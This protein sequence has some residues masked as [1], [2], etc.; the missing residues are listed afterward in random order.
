MTS[1]KSRRVRRTVGTGLSLAL[2]A[3]AG[4]AATAPLAS[5]FA[6][7]RASVVAPTAVTPKAATTPVSARVVAT[8]KIGVAPKALVATPCTG[9]ATISCELFARTGTTTVKVSASSSPTLTVWKFSDTDTATGAASAVLVGQVGVPMTITLHNNLP[10]ATPLRFSIP[11]LDG[12]HFTT[13]IAQGGTDTV[14]FTPDRA[15]TF[16]YQAGLGADGSRQ[17]SMGLVGALVV[18]PNPAQPSAVPGDDANQTKGKAYDAQEQGYDDEAV[19]VYT[20]VDTRLAANPL[21]FSMRSW[22]PQYH[23]VNGQA[24]PDTQSVVSDAGRT[25]MLRVV[26]GGILEKSPTLLGTR[27]TVVARGS[28]PLPTAMEVSGRLMN[29]GDTFDGRVT[30]PA[31]ADTRYALF[32][33]PGGLR[34]ANG[35]N[36][37]SKNAPALGGALVFLQAGG[38]PNVAPSGPKVST[39][40]IT[41]TPGVA[42]A[43]GV[44]ARSLTLSAKLSTADRGE[45]DIADGEYWIDNLDAGA[46]GQLDGVGA[47]KLTGFGATGNTVTVGWTFDDT[48]LAGLSSGLHTLWVRG[49]DSF[50]VWGPLTSTRFLVDNDGPTVS[51]LTLSDTFTGGP[52][53][54]DLD[55]AATI[56]DR[57]NGGSTVVDARAWIGTS[58]DP[59]APAEIAPQALLTNGPR[60]V[61]AADGTFALADLQGLAEGVHT[62]H[63]QGKDVHGHWGAVRNATFTV[64][65]TAPVVSK[66]DVVPTVTNGLN[67]SPAKPTTITVTATI[68][69]NASPITT[70]EAYLGATPGPKDSPLGVM[71][72][73]VGNGTWT[74][75]VPLA[76]LAGI[77]ADGN[78]AFSV[79]AADA[80]GNRSSTSP[81]ASLLLD[82]T[83]PAFNLSALQGVGYPANRMLNISTT[84]TDLGS[85]LAYAEYF[86]GADP[87]VG[88]GIRITPV[89]VAN[90]PGKWTV[91]AAYDLAYA[92]LVDGRIIT[93]T[94]RVRDNA[95]NWSQ[96]TR[97]VDLTDLRLFR[98][99]FQNVEAQPW[100]GTNGTIGY[101]GVPTALAGGRSASVNL[102]TAG[103]WYKTAAS[104]PAVGASSIDVLHASFVMGVNAGSRTG[105]ANLT[106][107]LTCNP[108]GRTV[109][110]GQSG[111][112]NLVWVEWGRGVANGQTKFR[113]NV[114][115]GATV[116]SSPWRTVPTANVYT[117]LVDWSS[118]TNKVTTLRVNGTTITVTATTSASHV[119]QVRLGLVDVP[120]GTDVGGLR[121]DTFVLS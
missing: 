46:T 106:T 92:N 89:P 1:L 17:V 120:A 49:K 2:V 83:K 25:V 58:D 56:D 76:W 102:N 28:R 110:A 114:R 35:I 26:N 39:I 100:T 36:A 109:F 66:V 48:Q 41:G 93:A 37:A 108:E 116:T 61:A 95:L 87:G 11:Q 5:A 54:T 75:D 88:R 91:S 9:G 38:V 19:L 68:S 6:A 90:Q 40:A 78:V 104:I 7:A 98:N 71:L 101:V 8:P 59:A 97:T 81:A 22:A 51:G 107:Q 111:S 3:G 23:L 72:S 50:G 57:K 64:D 115:N 4:V 62:L 112:T 79:A 69:D 60:T 77:K 84:V 14:T 70:V 10:V 103:S 31:Q 30:L 32:D 33:T 55:I 117:I 18:R 52:D 63:V 45:G 16:T 21:G 47:T 118:G 29:T 13:S 34:N 24:Y 74:G 43:A 94:L 65:K 12:V 44:T 53:A 96:A 85:G 42:S 20:D 73:P 119:G 113:L 99:G 105:C 82:R 80:A 121:F 15:G 67:G 86:I 27:M